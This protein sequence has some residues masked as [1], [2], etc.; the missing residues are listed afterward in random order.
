MERVRRRL[1]QFGASDLA[2][3]LW[4]LRASLTTLV[5]DPDGDTRAGYHLAGSEAAADRERLLTASRAVADRLAERALR[6][7]G[8]ATWIGLDFVQGRRWSLLPLGTDLYDGLPGVALFLA[9][10][11]DVTGEARHT[12]LARAA[13]NTLRRWLLPHKRSKTVRGIGGFAGWGGILYTMA[14]LGVLWDEPGLFAEAR[15]LAETVP[16]WIERDRDLDIIG[17]AAGG[18]AGLLCLDRADPSPRVRDIALRCGDHLLSRA[19]PMPAGLGWDP[20][21]RCRGPLTGFSHGAAGIAWALLELAAHTGD[22]RFRS[23]ALGGIAYERSLF[24][25]EAGN[26]PDLRVFDRLSGE[27]E[28]PRPPCRIAW[29]HGAPGIGL[30]RLR[31][32][33]HVDDPRL[34]SEVVA[35]VRT[36]LAHGFGRDHTLCHG[37]LGNL[38]FVSEAA[39]AFP[40]SRWGADAGRLAAS[41]LNS[42]ARDGWLCAN[43]LGVESPG[44]MTGLAGVGYGLLRLAEPARVPSVLTLAAANRPLDEQRP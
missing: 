9:Y 21:F 6:G 24:R 43:P 31:C 5:D 32:L 42:I 15:D 8:E 4:F 33:A 2:R 30:A 41:L 26:W 13:L 29:C 40:E 1:E 28:E 17:G 23:A 27:G 10:L 25:A 11:G 36:T 20:P 3:Q 19:R 12:E 39:R 37:D 14:H 22:D 38:E 16:G 35:A 18:L 7:D 44:L 34:R